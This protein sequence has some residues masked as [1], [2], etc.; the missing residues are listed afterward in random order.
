MLSTHRLFLMQTAFVVGALI[1]SP[2]LARKKP[3]HVATTNAFDCSLE[4]L[5]LAGAVN[6]ERDPEF[7][8]GLG[9]YHYVFG[10]KVA[11]VG[12][13]SVTVEK[14][15]GHYRVQAA[16]RSRKVIDSL[17]R[18]R[19]HGHAK[20][21]AEEL[22]P[23]EATIH[24]RKRKK[25]RD[26]TMDFQEDGDVESLVVKYKNGKEYKRNTLKLG[27]GEFPLDP[28][29]ATLLGRSLKW[30]SGKSEVFEVLTG[31]SSFLV[32]LNC[33]GT[34][35][36][37]QNKVKREVWKLVPCVKDLD[38]PEKDLKLG[39]TT[40]YLTTDTRDVILIENKSKLGNIRVK[41]D[42]FVPA[43]EV[44]PKAGQDDDDRARP[45]RRGP[46]GKRH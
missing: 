20:I 17:Y 7:A 11:D 4:N 12:K 28:F 45:R 44:D 31:K 39:N 34:E 14:E 24:E 33:V 23:V 25:E 22:T 32:K 40:I 38:E 29:T 37:K 13:A 19:Y 26:M 43:G 36:I 35:T 27:S 16:G 21:N 1:A 46:P 5:T 2:A 8:P 41:L 30:E 15:D 18:M 42:R 10:W 9:T 6:L 3:A